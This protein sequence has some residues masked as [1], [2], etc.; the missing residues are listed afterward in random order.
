[1]N[2][3]FQK[4]LLLIT[5]ISL[6]LSG[7]AG[8]KKYGTFHLDRELDQMFLSY[9]V[10][11]DYNYYTSGGY[12]KP[13]AILGVHKDYQM[14]TD[15]WVSI[16]NVNSAQIEKWI[17]TIDP[18][19]IGPGNNYLAY[20]ILDPEGK[21]VGFWYSIQNYTVV[22]FLEENKIEVYPPELIQPGDGFDGDGRG[23]RIKLR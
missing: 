16:P 23:M 8:T 19:D 11:P 2:E 13:N 3:A 15:F 5:V 22:K 14:V 12:N 4:L 10:L 17:R 7:C 18:E 21:Q 1:M 9:Q 20:Y 6:L